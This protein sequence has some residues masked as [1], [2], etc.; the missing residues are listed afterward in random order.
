MWKIFDCDGPYARAVNKVLDYLL[1]GCLWT[2]FSLPVV[3][4]GASCTAL[5]Y[6]VN[7]VLR[8]GEEHPVQIFWHAFKSNFKQATIIWAVQLIAFVILGVDM[9]FVYSLYLDQVV[10]ADVVL[11]CVVIL[12][13][14]L[15]FTLYLFPYIASFVNTTREV[16][17]N[18]AIMTM[19]NFL[20]SLLLLALFVVSVMGSLFVPLGVFVVP[21]GYML[22]CSLILNRVFQKYIPVQETEET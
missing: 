14:I 16:L 15:M 3:T 4:I 8:Q 1:L 21:S 11:I 12:A 17:K 6:T 9:Y 22:I 19:I 10:A 13:F 2:I 18:C 20:W 5:Y 7:K